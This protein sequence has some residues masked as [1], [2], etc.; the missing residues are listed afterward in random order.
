MPVL[1]AGTL[2]AQQAPVT[3]LRGRVIDATGGAIPAAT[4][5]VTDA[6]NSTRTLVTGATGTFVLGGLASGRY[7]VRVFFP[8]FDVYENTAVDLTEGRTRT[9]L[10]SLSIAPISEEI[11]LKAEPTFHRGTVVLP[12]SDAEALPDD[13]DDLAAD[14][15]AL[16]GASGAPQGA[17]LFI[18]GFTA[19]RLPPKASIR[20]LRTNQNPYSAAYDRVGFGRIEVFTKPGSDKFRGQLSFNF[21][22]GIFNSR[23]PF[24]PSGRP[25]FQEGLVGANLSGAL[26]KRASGTVDL[27]TR[28]IATSAVINATVLE[29]G[30]AHV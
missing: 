12:G 24:Y 10:I 5:T 1:A 18:D 3:R 20:E 8:G 17:Q 14:L 13:P 15:E 27:E 28:E 25:L 6:Q 22:H 7:D 16:A 4:V 30:R 19:A 26:S 21:G 11:T 23:N 9:L 29:I 2:L